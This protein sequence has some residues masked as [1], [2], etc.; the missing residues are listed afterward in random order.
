MPETLLVPLFPFGYGG[1]EA[2]GA[3]PGPDVVA[4]I[5]DPFPFGAVVAAEQDAG[6]PVL[7]EQGVNG[8]G[9]GLVMLAKP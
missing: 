7:G 4:G 1:V 9:H 3:H 5:R 2:V 8:L 6:H